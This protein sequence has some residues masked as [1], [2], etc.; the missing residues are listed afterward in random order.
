[1]VLVG[2]RHL[3][4]LRNVIVVILRKRKGRPASFVVSLLV[5]KRG[6]GLYK[7]RHS[8]DRATARGF[9]VLYIVYAV[10]AVIIAMRTSLM[11]AWNVFD[12]MPPSFGGAGSKCVILSI[13]RS[14]MPI[15]LLGQTRFPNE[16]NASRKVV[17]TKI[18]CAP[19]VSESGV[20]IRQGNSL[21]EID[22]RII[23]SIQWLPCDQPEA[24][25]AQSR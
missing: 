18:L 15:S 17:D 13:D 10:S 23:S 4:N 11:V 16:H 22:R 6:H 12:Y 20:F 1:M 7:Y 14:E 21:V 3:R 9:R 2:M 5:W 25:C 8:L 24:G 19:L